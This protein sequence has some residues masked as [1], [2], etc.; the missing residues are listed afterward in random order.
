VHILLANEYWRIPSEAAFESGMRNLYKKNIMIFSPARSGSTLISLI[1]GAHSKITNFGESHWA[2][3]E[4]M[5]RSDR[6]TASE[7]E[8]RAHGPDCPTVKKI[9]EKLRYEN[10]LEV[11]SEYSE[12]E[13]I[14]TSNKNR[15]HYTKMDYDK[16]ENFILL[17]YKPPEVWA[18][19]YLDG[20]KMKLPKDSGEA[21]KILADKFYQYYDKHIELIEGDKHLNN[22]FVVDYLRLVEEGQEYVEEICDFLGIDFESEMMQ[23]NTYLTSGDLNQHPIGGNRRTY[24][25]LNKG[26]DKRYDKDE[27]N[28]YYEKKYLG[29]LDEKNLSEIRSDPRYKQLTQRLGIKSS[30]KILIEDGKDSLIS[31]SVVY[32][33]TD[34]LYAGRMSAYG[35]YLKLPIVDRMVDNG[36]IYK[37]AIATAGSTLMCHSTEWSGRYPSDLHG[38]VPYNERVYHTPMEEGLD[39]VF[40]DFIAKGFDVHIVL[41]KKRPGKTYDSFSPIFNLWPEDLNIVTIPDWDRPGGELLRRRDQI[42]KAEELVSKSVNSG[43]PAFVFVK[44]HGYHRPEF[45]SKFLNYANQTMITYDDLY[46]AEIDEAMGELLDSYDYP[47]GACPDVWFAS[48]HGSWAGE[49]FRNHYGYHLHQE[50]VHVPLIS[51]KGGG[52]KIDNIF[53]M[54]E[55]RRLLTGDSPKLDEEYIFAETLYPGQINLNP[56]SGIFSMAKLM[57]RKGKYKYI[58]S[59][60][61]IEGDGEPS[62]ELYDLDYDP[63]EKFNMAQAFEHKYKD[64]ARV[65]KSGIPFNRI[66]Q[67]IH[68]DPKKARKFEKFIPKDSEGLTFKREFQFSGWPEIHEKLVELREKAREYWEETGRGAHF[69]F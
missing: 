60:H 13:F 58:Y 49:S 19:S 23:F 63:L 40:T 33:A 34:R 3:E 9:A 10:H 67:R 53:S 39:T 37:N 28:I 30:A 6:T 38:E 59:M 48:D 12:T 2:S 31:Q 8:C 24:V 25:T 66:T 51:S 22:Y 55:V 21:A 44:C 50:I 45:R 62:E 29:F 54:K 64:V 20:K 56:D 46:N 61:G 43:R 32:V 35:G 65:A 4:S 69:K 5:S 52:K 57:V 18:G 16:T 41:V 42:M 15:S 11:L 68:S 1:F 14:L 36:T 17:I 47:D 27:N 26:K 7:W